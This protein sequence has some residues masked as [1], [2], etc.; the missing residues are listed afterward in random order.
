VRPRASDLYPLDL[1][2]PDYE[3]ESICFGRPGIKPGTEVYLLRWAKDME[4]LYY[5]ILLKTSKWRNHFR[6][7][8]LQKMQH[9]GREPH[10]SWERVEA[11]VFEHSAVSTVSTVTII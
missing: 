5:L 3:W 9:P 7:I 11:E 1:T 4:Y 10:V 2:E 8:G 6:R